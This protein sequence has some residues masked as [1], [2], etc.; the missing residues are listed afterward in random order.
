MNRRQFL[1]T[2]VAGAAV[3]AAGCKPCDCND[4]LCVSELVPYK[5]DWVRNTDTSIGLLK[6]LDFITVTDTV[7]N[8]QKTGYITSTWTHCCES[9]EPFG[10]TREEWLNGGGLIAAQSHGVDRESGNIVKQDLELRFA[11]DQGY[12]FLLEKLEFEP[13]C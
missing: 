1:A 3:L 8:A 9:G 11:G 10:I 5:F 13:V 6:H 7:L 2:G 12:I 4:T